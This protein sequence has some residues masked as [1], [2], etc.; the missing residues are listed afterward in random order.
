MSKTWSNVFINEQA[1]VKEILL[2]ILLENVFFA[3]LAALNNKII[4]LKVIKIIHTT[5]MINKI[6]ILLLLP[7]LV[8]GFIANGQ[9]SATID[10]G[11][12]KS[13]DQISAML[14]SLTNQT[15]LNRAN[16]IDAQKSLSF[17]DDAPYEFKSF[18]DSV[19]KHNLAKLQ[20]PI[21]L[22]YNDQVKQ[23]IEFYAHKV[24]LM[25]RVLGLSNLYFPMFEEVLDKE[26]LPME[27]KYLSIVES[28]LNPIA[29]SRC[30]ATGLW[31]F[32]YN[33]GILYDLKTTS[34]IDERRDP[35]KAT[36]AACQYFKDM[37]LIY[38]DWLLVIA[39][40]NCG[41]G[42]VNR[43]IMRSGGSNNFWEI[44]KYLPS[45][46]RAYVP[47]FIAVNYMM[48]Y[49]ADY[50]LTP[51]PPAFSYF[52]VDTV[53]VTKPLTFNQLS[54]A[55]NVPVD[56]L[57]YL[58]PIYKKG[59]IP[60]LDANYKLR[61]PLNKIGIYMANVD[62]IAKASYQETVSSYT[63]QQALKPNAT[64][65][66]VSKD[67]DKTYIVKSG[68]SLP[69]IAGRF[70][71]TTAELQKWNH[72]KGSLIYPGQ[73]LTIITK[74]IVKVEKPVECK[75]SCSVA[76]SRVSLS[77]KDSAL[78]AAE[79]DSLENKQTASAN[80]KKELVNNEIY[81]TIQPGDTLWNIARRYQGLTVQKLKEINKLSDN[82]TLTPGTKLK[83]LIGG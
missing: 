10:T 40:Y 46:T 75:D 21:A 68:E 49:A 77:P 36:V 15:F 73:K 32:M 51:E 43:A 13:Y 38:K 27:F 52:Q 41:A 82:F 79:K 9:T 14:D 66:T 53:T 25:K 81:I 1:F 80:D 22:D 11:Q 18:P 83:V 47:A 24:P 12:G 48:N 30:G 71:V 3:N 2:R 42:N 17:R 59:Y 26:G 70:G 76:I 8:F 72:I 62:A 31:Q 78:V 23:F 58:N 61:L 33:T 7:L 69:A 28:A 35:Y 16:Y 44:S 6:Y 50:N 29:C 5:M 60:A 65:E 34:Y 57:Q 4:S 45:E 56:E 37:Y 67:V 74:Q 20:S 39:A 63:Q 54:K 19:Y 64:Y 55:L